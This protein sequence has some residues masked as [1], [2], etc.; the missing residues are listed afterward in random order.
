[1]DLQHLETYAPGDAL[2]HRRNSM[3]ILRLGA[4]PRPG[5]ENSAIFRREKWEHMGTEKAN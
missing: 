2:I 5:V 3:W 1:V 4:A